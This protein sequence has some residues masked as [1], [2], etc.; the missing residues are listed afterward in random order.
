MSRRARK[1]RLCAP[2]GGAAAPA[3]TAKAIAFRRRI[4]GTRETPAL[5]T[6]D[7]TANGEYGGVTG[8]RQRYG[9]LLLALFATF[10]FGGI[11]QPS[12]LQRVLGTILVGATLTL[13]LYAAEIPLRRMR[14][15]SAVILAIVLGIAIASV[16]AKGSTVIG[17]AAIANALLIALAPPAVVIGVLHSLRTTGS[18]TVTVVAGALCLYLLVGL[19]FAFAYTAI[20]NLGGA[21][22]F[23]NGATA[24][25]DRSVYFSFVTLTT[26]GYGDYTPRTNFGHTLAISEAL[27]GQIYLVTV[28]ATIVARLAAGRA[29]GG[30]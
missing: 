28:V 5:A 15:A 22:Y 20:Q 12:N 14:V 9:M 19:F 29:G 30:E 4:G 26:L 24:T 7:V 18:V 25:Y 13:A 21:P 17:I 2:P 3:F 10:F 6:G 27:L 23:A 11:A 1:S 16:A 8:S